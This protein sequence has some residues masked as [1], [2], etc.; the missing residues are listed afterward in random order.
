MATSLHTFIDIFDASFEGEEEPIKLSKIVIPIIQRDYAQGRRETDIAR[1]RTRFLDALYEAIE[2][3]PITLD[4]VYGDLNSD[5]VLTPLDG[6]QRLTTLFLLHWYAAKKEKISSE[7]YAFLNNFSYVTRY[8]AR[9]FCSYLIKHEPSFAIKISEEIIDQAWFPLDWMQD[10][11]I[12]AMLV[13]IDAIDEKFSDVSDIWK[14]L[15][16]GAISFY[17]LPIKDMGLTDE[18]YIKMNSRGKPLTLFEHFKA[19]LERELNKVDKA[20][21]KRV[22]SKIDLDWT[23]MLWRYRGDDNLIDDEFLRYFHFI[24]DILYYKAGDTPLGKDLDEFALIKL[25]FS[26]ENKNAIS[27]IE[28]MESYFDCWASMNEKPQDFFER[29]LSNRHEVGKVMIEERYKID[30][31][32]DCLRNNGDWLGNGNRSFALNRVILLYAVVVYLLNKGKVSEEQFIRRF[33]IINNLTL[34]SE[35]EMSNS[36]TRAGGNRMPNILK[37]VDSVMVDGRLNLKLERN[38]NAVQINEENEK[39]IWVYNNPSKADDLYKLEDH[40]LLYGQIEVVGLDKPEYFSRFES[41]FKCNWDLIDCALLTMGNYLQKEKNEWRYQLGSK[42]MPKAWT[43]LFHR[44]S[45]EGFE[46]TKTSLRMLLSKFDSFSDDKLKKLISDFLKE[47]EK[48][49]R[50][51]WKYYYIKYEVFRTGRYGKYSWDNLTG[52]PYEMVA[53]WTER[54]LSQNSYQPFLKAI[55]SNHI[56]KDDFGLRLVYDGS[57]VQ[58]ENSAF[59]TYSSENN[60]EISRIDICQDDEGT[61][62]EDRIK[63]YLEIVKVE[64]ASEE[65]SD[66]ME[67]QESK[68]IMKSGGNLEFEIPT[69]YRNPH[70]VE[71]AIKLLEHYLNSQ[72]K[73]ITYGDLCKKLSFPENPRNVEVLLGEVSFTCKENGLPP[74]SALVVN[75]DTFIPGNGFFEAYYPEVKVSDRDKKFVEIYKQIEECSEWRALL[76]AYKTLS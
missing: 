76:E 42:K 59:V 19:E 44:S 14:K 12:A 48:N 53:M 41:L 32:E 62:T 11:T 66:I 2:R 23:D 34:N 57:Y 74:I 64:Q 69:E 38:F 26:A 15:K 20:A 43:N 29:V 45:A 75:K 63:K 21:A 71:V 25:F 17:F 39:L 4:F 51:D 49:Q 35:F 36:E 54:N 22:I 65:I 7:E 67:D 13:M 8:S 60:E 16:S 3:T 30:I 18:L 27:N 68:D 55:D 40:Y 50:Y 47:R 28:L 1:V 24:C 70:T 9:D 5:G 73:L 72:E 33:R 61:D 58:C 31:F 10:P 46:T 52:K 37:Q 6:Q 56:S